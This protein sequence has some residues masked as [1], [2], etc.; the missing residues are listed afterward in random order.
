MPPTLKAC[1][2]LPLPVGLVLV[3]L[4]AFLTGCASPRAS[5]TVPRAFSFTNDTFVF[6]NELVWEYG[7]DAQSN[8]VSRAREP[9]PEYAQR[10]FVLAEAAL[11]FFQAARFDTNQPVKGDAD[12]RRL[13][14]QVRNTNSRRLVPE[15]R[16]TLIPGYPDLRSFSQA[17][18]DVLKSECGGRWASYLQRGHWRMVFPFSRRHQA[19]Q[20]ERLLS[21]LRERKPAVVHLV[22]FPKL[23]I[24][25]AVLLYG[26]EERPD[27][28]LFRV[29]DPNQPE[30]PAEL[31]FSRSAR[32]FI[33]PQSDYF[34]GGRVDVYQVYHHWAY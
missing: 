10:C 19:H 20:A 24:N 16:K 3:L 2:R 30:A 12:Y 23:S 22:R 9:K 33:L 15:S 18:E 6:E 7:Y 11:Q 28:I 26:A 25:H 31:R 17:H 29:Y 14:R 4:L 34:K 13:V 32:T 1:N 5:T 27:E 8:W 21:Q